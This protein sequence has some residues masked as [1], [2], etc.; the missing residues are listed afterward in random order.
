MKHHFSISQLPILTVFVAFTVFF[1][2]CGEEVEPTAPPVVED[3]I[4]EVPKTED[5]AT[6]PDDGIDFNTFFSQLQGKWI[7]GERDRSNI[8]SNPEKKR[9][10]LRLGQATNNSSARVMDDY[11]GFIEFL[12]D[13]TY[14]FND[15]KVL[16]SSWKLEYGKFQIDVESK[17]LI[18]QGYGE[19]D[20]QE[21]NN[22]TVKFDLKESASNS[23]YSLEGVK[24]GF[25]DETEKTRMISKVWSLTDENDFGKEQ[26]DY[27]KNEGVGIYGENG[28][29]VDRI[30]PEGFIIF[31]TPSGTIKSA[32]L[33]GETLMSFDIEN[34]RWSED[35]NFILTAY[36]HT[37]LETENEDSYSLKIVELTENRLVLGDSYTDEEGNQYEEEWIFKVYQK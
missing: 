6:D 33:I 36:D 31:I 5:P 10:L 25:L 9:G 22:E 12:S 24:R 21:I 11:Q 35:G 13:T 26:L 1:Q 30:Y 32:H 37:N 7:F 20:I 16:Q 8:R 15:P 4:T 14:I 23:N 28:Q 17:K 27:L 34:W 29:I 19:I 2:G 3:P 18:L